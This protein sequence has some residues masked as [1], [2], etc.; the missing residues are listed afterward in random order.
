ML[1]DPSKTA[2]ENML[3]L[4]NTTNGTE[5]TAED[6]QFG[7]PEVYSNPAHPDHNTKVV[8]TGIGDYTG[9]MDIFY[10]R[11][12]LDL[13]IMYRNY[14]IGDYADVAAFMAYVATHN[15]VRGD[16]VRL[17]IDYIPN[18]TVDVTTRLLPVANSWLYMGEREI[19]FKAPVAP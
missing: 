2:F 15:E 4:L 11:L 16:N 3:A 17:E 19:V 18:G 8:L 13:E 5:Y 12:D 10:K 14:P 6:V 1:V 7:P 9:T